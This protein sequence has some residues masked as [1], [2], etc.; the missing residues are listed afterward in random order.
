MP[1]RVRKWLAEIPRLFGVKPS[2]GDVELLWLNDDEASSPAWGF[3]EHDR[4]RARYERD[5]AIHEAARL[6]ALVDGISVMVAGRDATVTYHP[7]GTT[8]TLARPRAVAGPT[9]DHVWIDEAL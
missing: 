9:V 5:V 3:D 1:Q 7:D 8:T 2:R 6:H 4:A